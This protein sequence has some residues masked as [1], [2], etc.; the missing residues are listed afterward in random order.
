[1]ETTKLTRSRV[2]MAGSPLLGL[3]PMNSAFIM[4]VC[5]RLCSPFSQNKF[6]VGFAS[7]KTENGE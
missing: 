4:V 2:T 6:L 5:I 7:K 1:M 3:V